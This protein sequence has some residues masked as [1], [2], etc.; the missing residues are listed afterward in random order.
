VDRI[1]RQRDHLNP[2]EWDFCVPLMSLP[3]CLGMKTWSDIPQFQKYIYED[4][5]LSSQWFDRLL[6]SDGGPNIGICWRAEENGVSRKHRSIPVEQRDA[7]SDARF[8]SLCPGVEAPSGVIDHTRAFLD[9]GVTAAFVS[10]LDLVISADTA[11]AHLAGALGI[12]TWI[13]LPQRSDWKW[14]TEESGP[15]WYPSARLFRQQHP[16]DWKP[17]MEEVADAL[18][19]L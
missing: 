7:R 9:W 3:R 2:A 11:V 12:P 1:V 6:H 16:T 17:V 15:V 13:V 10:N 19:A 18:R 5:R 8:F 14:A 4:K